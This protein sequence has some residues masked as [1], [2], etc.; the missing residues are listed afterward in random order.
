MGTFPDIQT[1]TLHTS[2]KEKA[3]K[4]EICSKIRARNRRWN[5]RHFSQDFK[6]FG[7]FR[8]LA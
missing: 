4:P 2:F 7:E 6:K 1:K 5:D 3:A 8:P